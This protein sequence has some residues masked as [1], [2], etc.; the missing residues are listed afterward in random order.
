MIPSR[1]MP[2]QRSSHFSSISMRWGIVK[3]LII[4]ES[5]GRCLFREHTLRYIARLVTR[6]IPA[7]LFLLPPPENATLVPGYRAFAGPV[8]VGDPCITASQS[9]VFEVVPSRWLAATS[10]EIPQT[11][12]ESGVGAVS[13]PCFDSIA[14]KTW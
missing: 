9:A 12:I 5:W 3:S 8:M 14:A 13:V 1:P 4:S 6:L 10:C 2:S 11:G 7:L